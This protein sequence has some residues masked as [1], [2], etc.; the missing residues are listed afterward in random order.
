MVEIRVRYC[1]KCGKKTKQLL[2]EI[3]LFPIRTN[4]NRNQK[5]IYKCFTCYTNSEE[6]NKA[7]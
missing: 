6:W 5:N 1:P 7:G 4:E 3:R 2:V